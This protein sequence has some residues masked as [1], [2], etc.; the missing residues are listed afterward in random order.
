M[1]WEGMTVRDLIA[2]LQQHD[3]DR[4]V[5]ISSDDYERAQDFVAVSEVTTD[6]FSPD[7]RNPVNL[8]LADERE[9]FLITV[10]RLV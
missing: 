2:A 4:L 5:V 3:P 8:Q 6:T 7:R 10:V 1:T 9:T